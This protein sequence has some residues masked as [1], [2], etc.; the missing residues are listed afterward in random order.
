MTETLALAI[1]LLGWSLIH[2]LWQGLA[3]AAVAAVAMRGAGPD[4]RRRH[5][6]ALTGL[7]VMASLAPLTAATRLAASHARPPAAPAMTTRAL[8]VEAGAV[9]ESASRRITVRAVVDAVLPWLVATWICGVAVLLGRLTFAW[10]RT[11][12]LRRHSRPAIGPPVEAVSRQAV[13]FGL[14]PPAVRLTEALDS[15]AVVGILHPAVMIPESVLHVLD[16]RQLEAVLA[17]EVA[18]LARRDPLLNLVQHGIEILLFFQPAARWLS[19]RARIERERCCDD[20]AVARTGDPVVYAAAL[21]ELEAARLPVAGVARRLALSVA[22]SRLAPR[23]RRLLAETDGRARGYRRSGVAAAAIALSALPASFAGGVSWSPAC[24]LADEARP[25]IATQPRIATI[26]PSNVTSRV[27]SGRVASGTL[28]RSALLAGLTRDPE[29]I[30]ALL[31]SIEDPR[32]SVREKA[33]LALGMIGD[34]HATDAL[35]ERLDDASPAVREK[36]V[37]ALGLLGGEEARA[38]VRAARHDPDHGVR[39]KARKVGFLLR[40]DP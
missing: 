14:R 27:D 18:H 10:H 31:E 26:A 19:G 6:L 32:A 13:R 22:G 7:V 33:T 36:A 9:R 17:H 25:R 29:A 35:I 23:I 4:P 24:D 2:L 15:P 11:R 30:P 38:A 16:G 37:V 40:D 12:T 21:V 39:D 20:L 34:R 8:A 5:A 3:V 28:E 1:D